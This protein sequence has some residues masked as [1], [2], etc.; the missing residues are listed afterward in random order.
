MIERWGDCTSQQ[1]ANMVEYFQMICADCGVGIIIRH[2]ES[3]E[4]FLN[5]YLNPHDC[6]PS[7]AA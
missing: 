2:L 5:I 4:T 7:E 6:N 3:K 1:A